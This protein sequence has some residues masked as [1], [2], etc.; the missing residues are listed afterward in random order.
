MTDLHFGRLVLCHISLY[1][2][3]QDEQGQRDAL[4]SK[5]VVA[6]VSLSV[7]IL[8]RCYV[9]HFTAKS[10]ASRYDDQFQLF[11]SPRL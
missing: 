1:Y 3:A 8:M 4:S 6:Q 11:A 7:H 2:T 5:A 9:Y 10:V